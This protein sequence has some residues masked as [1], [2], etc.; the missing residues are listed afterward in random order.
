MNVHRL[1]G[2]APTPLAH[3]LKGLGIL[4]L[5]AEQADTAAR[6][7]WEKEVFCLTSSLDEEALIH[8]VLDRYAPTPMFNP[9]GARSGFYPGSSESSSRKVL[10]LIMKSTASRLEPY[11]RA[12]EAVRG[13]IQEETGG[14]KPTDKQR[15]LRVGLTLAVRNSAR[16]AA[17]DWMDAVTAIIDR[18]ERTIEQPSLLGTGGSEGSGS[19]TSAYMQAIDECLLKRRWDRALPEAI[20]GR[21]RSPGCQWNQ[22]FGQFLP[23]NLGSPWDLLLAFEGACAVRS[24]VA[25]RAARQG[26]RWLASPFFVPPSASGYASGARLDEY[27]LNKGK[28][29]PGRGEQWFPIWRNP[30]TFRELLHMMLEGRASVGRGRAQDAFSLARAARSLGTQRG[31]TEFVRYGY[32]QRNNLATH[33]AVPLGR[34]RVSERASPQ[35]AC[36]DD[37][38]AWLPRVRRETRTKVAP[39]R[40]LFAERRLADALFT[41]TQHADEPLRWQTVLLR[42]GDIEAVQVTGSGFGAGPIPPL[43]PEWATAADDHSPDLRL[44]L[45]CALQATAFTRDGRAVGG[46]RR[47]WLPLDRSRYRVSGS[48][49]QARLLVGTEVVL[50]GRDGVDDAIALV[51]RRLIEAAQRG[52][53]RLPLVAARGA[54]ARASELSLFL[55]GHVD[56]DRTLALARALMAIDARRWAESHCPPQRPPE[57]VGTPDDAWLA[58]RLALLPWRLPD[59]PAIGAD[60]AIVRRLVSGDVASALDLALRRLRAAGVV[61]TVRTGTVP[62]ATA[63]R[64]AA[65]LAFPI[66]PA[67]A[68]V[69][70]RRLAPPTFK[71]ASP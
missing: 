12:I 18:S 17:S 69:F 50:S 36:L 23:A 38:E 11:R 60:P 28:E 19:Y 42:L 57:P 47:N 4:R 14:N 27:L 34:V 66:T 3:Y 25:T 71:E 44:A 43:R 58:I 56:A 54:A 53:R 20:F 49:G 37:L 32:L 68:E 30:I 26:H 52:E 51:E 62:S 9:W 13:A 21:N 5:V 24:G 6:G 29:L 39:A 59:R 41:L 70:L 15:E 64:W 67:T 33:F 45:A 63:R 10:G 16:G 1:E 7:W 48:G 40:L 55:A 31:I 8:F 61:T 2:C 35:L 65:A 22:S 46:V